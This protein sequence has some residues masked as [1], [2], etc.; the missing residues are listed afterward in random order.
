MVFAT[1]GTELDSGLSLR[2]S[3]ARS[4][5]CQA[6]ALLTCLGLTNIAK[7]EDQT[8]ILLDGRTVNARL[9]ELSTA[10]DLTLHEAGRSE[11]IPLDQLTIW[12]GFRERCDRAWILLRDG[13]L[14]VADLMRLEPDRIVVAGRNWPETTLAREQVIGIL[15]RPPLDTAARDALLLRAQREERSEDRLLLEHGD[16]LRGVA[17]DRILPEPGAFEPERIHWPVP[18]ARDPVKLSLERVTA[19]LFATGPEE[20]AGAR[21]AIWVG[22]SDGSR[23]RATR[24]ARQDN[25]LTFELAGGIRLNTD[26]ATL[27]G[28]NPL[29]LV[30]CVQP[31]DSHI[32]YVSDLQPLGY[33][34]IPYLSTS[35]PYHVDRSVSGGLLRFGD[36]VWIKGVGM[37]SSSRL[38]YDVPNGYHS[39]QAELAIDRRAGQAGSVAYRVYV[40]DAAG[41]WSKAFESEVVRGGQ[42]PMPMRVDIRDAVRFALIVDF[43]DRADQWDHANWLNV[44]L[45]R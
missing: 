25:H 29:E 43:A 36:R 28:S 24:F 45:V 8:A 4:F 42:A 23:L 14:I 11:A 20:S 34:H 37:H 17:P 30:V 2:L 16:E 3:P 10:G 5:L 22:L 27:T 12:G 40:Q 19:L 44:R 18:G 7:A 9:G 41:Q 21:D 32:V 31:M 6:L 26:G 1:P 35:W 15:F 13:S 33:R 38:A 39:L